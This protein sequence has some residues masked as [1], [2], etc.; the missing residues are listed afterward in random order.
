MKIDL[1]KKKWLHGSLM[2]NS[3]Y[4]EVYFVDAES[5]QQI[6][7]KHGNKVMFR[8]MI[9]AEYR[10]IIST[11]V[12]QSETRSKKADQMENEDLYLQKSI[13]PEFK[14]FLQNYVDYDTLNF[15]VEELKKYEVTLYDCIFYIST[16][17]HTEKNYTNGTNSIQFYSNET[18][19]YCYLI[20]KFKIDEVARLTIVNEFEFISREGEKQTYK[21]D[22]SLSTEVLMTDEQELDKLYHHYY[23]NKYNNE[24]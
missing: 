7:L 21:R 24:K 11:G 15:L 4:L 2:I 3:D 12:F 5:N 20:Y 10:N 22:T 9:E 17:D 16:E 19:G 8:G 13:D 18:F 1:D 14:K 23:E 6:L